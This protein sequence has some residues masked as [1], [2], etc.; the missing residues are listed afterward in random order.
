MIMEWNY[1]VVDVTLKC[2]CN[3]DKM[4]RKMALDML[5]G[6]LKK[7]SP[8]LIDKIGKVNIIP[9]EKLNND[10]CKNCISINDQKDCGCE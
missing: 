6:E 8:S 9:T 5:N 3:S 7:L 1:A 4:S 10:G 2:P